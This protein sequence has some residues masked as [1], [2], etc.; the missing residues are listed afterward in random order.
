M[1]YLADDNRSI[2]MRE[3]NGS[4][5]WEHRHESRVEIPKPKYDLNQIDCHQQADSS[6]MCLSNGLVEVI[7]FKIQVV[8]SND[9]DESR[10]LKPVISELNYR[11][12]IPDCF[13]REIYFIEGFLVVD[14]LLI[15]KSRYSFS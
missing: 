10:F 7:T 8:R 12:I 2:G 3:L 14:A 11:S 6:I 5:P 4:I 1:I 13:E 15:T 9:E